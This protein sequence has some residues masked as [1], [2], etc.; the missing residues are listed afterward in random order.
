MH[1][2]VLSCLICL[3]VLIP[4]SYADDSFSPIKSIT[5]TGVLKRVF[6]IGGETT[7]WYLELDHSIAVSVAQYPAPS[8]FGV[9]GRPNKDN[10]DVV[11]LDRIEIDYHQ[12]LNALEEKKIE[13]SG[14]LKWRKGVEREVYF[15]LLASSVKELK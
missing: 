4:L 6:M 15:Y 7:G 12:S 14:F 13:A 2:L 1:K 11:T 10:I 8:G 3:M 9:I 5:L